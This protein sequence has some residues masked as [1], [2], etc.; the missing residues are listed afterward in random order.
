MFVAGGEFKYHPFTPPLSSDPFRNDPLPLCVTPLEV[1]PF[2]TPRTTNTMH[3][4]FIFF[5]RN[6]KIHILTISI[7]FR[8][9]A[10]LQHSWHI[11]GF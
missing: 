6:T 4:F 1:L 11:R 3:Y 9:E 5:I 2:T 8:A 7:V 10:R